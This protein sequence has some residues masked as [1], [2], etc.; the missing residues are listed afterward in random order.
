M[1]TCY[2]ALNLPQLSGT[3]TQITRQ[4]HRIQPKFSR[5]IIAVNVDMRW[6]IRLMAVKVKPVGTAS[7]HHRH[8]GNSIKPSENRTS[9][10]ASEAFT[11]L[12]SLF[13]LNAQVD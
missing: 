6:L 2:Q 7:E 3:E 9:H 8:G 5:K 12:R 1:I 10:E 4:H 11:G 13:E